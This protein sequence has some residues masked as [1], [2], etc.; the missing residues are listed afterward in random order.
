MFMK[1]TAFFLSVFL[2]AIGLCVFSSQGQASETPV[3][4]VG[5][6]T[7][8]E[9]SA[10]STV[11]TQKGSWWRRALSAFTGRDSESQP[12]KAGDESIP[13]SEENSLPTVAPVVPI[14]SGADSIQTTEPVA[15]RKDAPDAKIEIMDKKEKKKQSKREKAQ[16]KAR[17]EALEKAVEEQVG[18]MRDARAREMPYLDKIYIR[19][20]I[21]PLK[22]QQKEE[23]L[24]GGAKDLQDLIIR[25]QSV[26]TQS[27]AAHESIALYNRRVLMAFRKLFPEATFNF[28]DREGLINSEAFSGDDWHVTL[29]QPIFN[30]G[31]LWNTLL[32]E[33]ANLEASRKQ[34]DKTLSDLVFDLSRAYFEYQRT[35][36]TAE[37]HRLAVE[38]MKRFADMSEEKFNL[39]IISEIERLNVQSLY[40]QMQFDLESANQELEIAK[41]DLQKYLDLSVDDQF[42]L[43]KIYDLDEVVQGQAIPAG[44]APGSKDLPDVFKGQEKAPELSKLIDLSY[45][46]RPELQV[47]AAKLQVM[48]L[49]ERIRWGE[50]LPKANLTYQFGA[51]G[52]AYLNNSVYNGSPTG[53]GNIAKNEPILKKEWQLMLELNWN[54]G[55]NK[56]N[57]TFDRNKK[58]PSIT[59]FDQASGSVLRK[60]GLTFGVLDGLD[61]FVNVKQAEVDKLNQVVELEKAEKQVLQDVKQAYYDYQKSVIQVNST[62]KR[63]EYRKRLGEFAEHRLSKKEIELS[64][65]LQA[66][67]DLVRE[68]GELHKALKEYFSAKAALN[69]AV[70]IQDFFNMDNAQKKNDPAPATLN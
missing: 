2:M 69:H 1:K 37:E 65:Y 18:A 17:A 26:N 48:R 7:A 36:Q 47:E 11:D 32:Q 59:Q 64:E 35:L 13:Q 68:K 38:K 57:Y 12:S 5:I 53:Y 33:K 8:S 21:T 14:Q 22:I 62:V 61:A 4:T 66:E 19:T 67:S 60:N 16:D 43:A 63:L 23:F 70:G 24:G 58:A 25:A 6:S 44:T 27:K 56:V 30:G 31:V 45:G 49:G 28:N 34:Y 29:R 52:E 41:L 10:I 40:S 39:K 55:G 42:T 3:P 50:F 54:V 9:D 15:V 46:H 20:S 51:L